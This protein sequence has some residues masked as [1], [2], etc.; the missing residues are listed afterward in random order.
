MAPYEALYVQVI[1]KIRDRIKSAQ[2]RQKSY[3]DQRRK[4]IEFEVGEK[5]FLKVAPIKG[6]LRFGK[7]G[8]LRPRFIDPFEILDRIENVAYR[9]ALPP[10]LSVVHNVFHVSML[11]KYVHDLEHVISYD[12]LEVQKDLTYEETPLEIV[13]RKT[14]ALRNKEI[15]LVK[16]RWKNHGVEEATWEKEE[17]IKAKYPELFG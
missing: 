2:D 12:S 8:K 3:A 6:V 4:S 17:E 13:E 5:V 10:R 14:H 11:R 7:K 16:V 1:D 9:L 15:A